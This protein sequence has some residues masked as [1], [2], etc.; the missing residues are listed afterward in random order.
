MIFVTWTLVIQTIDFHKFT[1]KTILTP[2]AYENEL[3]NV[4]L[5]GY[6][7]D[8]MEEVDHIV[9][10][11]A[12]IFDHKG[13]IAASLWITGPVFRLSLDEAQRKV[14]DVIQAGLKVSRQLGFGGNF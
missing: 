10:A 9:C 5:L 11:A 13:K 2:E 7:L 1:E 6:A 12:P 3:A 8:R 4:R 14:A